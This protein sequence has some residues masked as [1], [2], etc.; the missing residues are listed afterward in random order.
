MMFD[1]KQK[2]SPETSAEVGCRRRRPGACNSEVPFS[3]HTP[4][5]RSVN[6][7]LEGQRNTGERKTQPCKVN[8]IRQPFSRHCAV[9]PATGEGVPDKMQGRWSGETSSLVGP[10]SSI[11]L[12]GT[13]LLPLDGGTMRSSSE[14]VSILLNVGSVQNLIPYF[15]GA[16][17]LGEWPHPLAPLSTHIGRSLSSVHDGPWRE[18]PM[19]CLLPNIFT[20][21]RLLRSHHAGDATTRWH[22]I[23]FL[24]QFFDLP[25]KLP[26][27]GHG[28]RE[29]EGIRRLHLQRP[30]R[31]QAGVGI[32]DPN[33]DPDPKP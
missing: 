14:S 31:T 21:H 24:D 15:W 8:K 32:R 22:M 3:R 30:V 20:S 1:S 25:L 12:L 16:E 11:D 10:T 13:T 6:A 23:A 19:P 18:P 5:A 33:P 26:D 17:S 27:P 9:E 2:S 4:L 29:K 28:T 7:T